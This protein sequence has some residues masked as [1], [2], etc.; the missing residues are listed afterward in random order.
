[1]RDALGEYLKQIGRHRLLT[2]DEEIAL[3]RQVQA[4]KTDD[5]PDAKRKATR[6]M[7]RLMESNL[8]LVVTI[9]KRWHRQAKLIGEIDFLD[10]VQEGNLGLHHAIKKFD[11]SKGYRFST[12][13]YWW[14]ESYLRRAIATKVRPVRL[15][16]HMGDKLV[17]INKVTEQMIKTGQPVTAEAIAHAADMD[18][19]TVRLL[20]NHSKW[21][22]SLDATLLE[23]GSDSWVDVLLSDERSNIA[24]EAAEN[25]HDLELLI[26]QAELSEEEMQAIYSVHWEEQPVR[27]N[28]AYARAMSKLRRVAR[29]QNQLRIRFEEQAFL[30]RY[31]NQPADAAYGS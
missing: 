20:R 16:C 17:R 2:A 27:R 5:S 24:Q 31:Y 15:P 30:S 21:P 29:E 13:A 1:M 7:Q 28:K 10:L 23:D 26:E 14:I 12:Y 11:P 19:E 4:A 9:T 6:A 8:R 25:R 18:P 22:V 3:A